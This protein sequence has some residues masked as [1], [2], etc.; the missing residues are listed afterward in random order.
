MTPGEAVEAFLRHFEAEQAPSPHT[1]SA[2]RR[3]LAK[4]LAYMDAEGL[5]S[6]KSQMK[7]ADASGA[8]YALIFGAD[9]LAREEVTLKALRDASVAQSTR[10]LADVTVWASTLQSPAP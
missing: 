6:F 5:A 8:T 7:K 3:D 1:L 9:E 2:Y 10:P 4:L